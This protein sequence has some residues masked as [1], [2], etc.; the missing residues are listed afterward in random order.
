MCVVYVALDKIICKS[1][2]SKG[3]DEQVASHNVDPMILHENNAERKLISNRNL[4][5]K[6]KT[7]LLSIGSLLCWISA[8]VPHDM[9]LFPSLGRPSCINT[10]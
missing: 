5:F 1:L 3:H 10:A 7:T 2:A 6:L 8:S 4:S 9:H